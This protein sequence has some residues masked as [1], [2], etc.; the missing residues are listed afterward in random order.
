MQLFFELR[1][2]VMDGAAHKYLWHCKGDAG[3]KPCMLCLNLYT[4]QSGVAQ[5]DGTRLLVCD[6]IDESGL[7]IATDAQVRGTVNRLAV[8]STTDEP[9]L[10]KKRETAVGFRHEPY[11]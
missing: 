6:A 3:L 2:F 7:K 8:R 1:V 10:F 5:E 11:Y 4:R 9:S